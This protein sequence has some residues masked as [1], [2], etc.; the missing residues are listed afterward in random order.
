MIKEIRYNGFTET[1]S[2]YECPDG[3]LAAMEGLVNEDGGLH[4]ILMPTAMFTLPYGY[5]VVFIHKNTG[6]THYIIRNGNYVYWINEPQHGATISA[7]TIT[8]NWLYTFSSTIYE[9]NAVGNTLIIL[10]SDGIHYFLW[11]G[12]AYANLGI[13]LPELPVSFGLQGEMKTSDTFFFEFD[14]I[15]IA[16]LTNEFSDN[17]KQRIGD[18]VLAQVNKFIAD[19]ATNDGR[20]IYSFLV[21]YAYRLYDQTL[22][23]HSSPVL[24]VAT[25][26]LAPQCFVVEWHENEN[27]AY[28]AECKVVAMVHQ[29]DYKALISSAQKDI[30]IY[31]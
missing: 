2:D 6:Y 8:N 20:F 12:S 21:R 9:F 3:D 7:S 19:K 27:G 5:D 17:N 14:T 31:E 25:S 22:T 24:M 23:M 30:I 1:P 26:D 18:A 16:D 11:K 29:L 28:G 13:H 15:P 10:A 4:P